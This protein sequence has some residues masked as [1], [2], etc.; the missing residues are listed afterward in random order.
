MSSA[1]PVHCSSLL[2]RHLRRWPLLLLAGV[3][4]VWVSC[5]TPP[6]M[7]RPIALLTDFG[8]QDPYVAQMKGAI[9]SIYPDARLVDLSHTIRSHDVRQGSYFLDKAVRHFPAD[10]IVVAVVDPGVGSA[11]AAVALQTRTGRIFIG[12]DNGLFSHVVLREK[13]AEARSI[14]NRELF[15]TPDVS[16][17]FHGRDI[18][19]P[20]AAHLAAG[21]SFSSVGPVMKKLN[22]LSI[23]PPATLGDK[24]NGEIS[25]IDGFGNVLTNIPREFLDPMPKNALLRVLVGGKT[26]SLPFIANYAEAPDKRPFIL[27]NSDDEA[28]IAVKEGSAGQFLKVEAGQKIILQR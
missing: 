8:S 17:T 28:E 4:L 6:P 7:N 25:H 18:F 1:L 24:V 3:S 15:R 23:N 11:R 19:G 14:E 10:T 16:S 9:L 22:L 2:H 5:S 27:I 21:T 20:V 12:P 13:L 26:Y